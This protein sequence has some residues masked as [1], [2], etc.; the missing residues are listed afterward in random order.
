MGSSDFMRKKLNKR[1]KKL[2]AERLLKKR[3]EREAL[4]LHKEVCL[5]LNKACLLCDK[6]ASVVHHYR[7]Q[8]AY[9][10]MKFLIEN[11]I[12]LC[13]G[14]HF[15]LH[16]GNNALQDKIRDIKGSIWYSRINKTGN[17]TPANYKNLKWFEENI[18]Y[19]KG[20]LKKL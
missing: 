8:G 7:P 15:R 11:G 13:A 14:C 2:K 6:P 1:E 19:L 12:S 16:I 20:V 5:K 3:K 4:E 9:A 10:H 17:K 18:T